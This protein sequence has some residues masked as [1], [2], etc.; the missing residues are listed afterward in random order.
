MSCARSTGSRSTSA[1]RRARGAARRER[2]RE[3]HAAVRAR[4]DPAPAARKRAAQ[5]HRGDPAQRAHA[6]RLPAA[7]GRHRLPGVQ[8]DPEPHGCR[9]RPGAAPRRRRRLARGAPPRRRSCWPRSAWPSGSRTAR[10]SC[11][12]GSS[13]AW[14][15]PRALALD[16][17]LLLADEPTAHLDYVQVD[18][19]L[20]LLREIADAGRMV[21]VATHDERLVPLADGVVELS[22]RHLEGV[23]ARGEVRLAPGEILFRQGDLSDLV[24]VV[25]HGR[26]RAGPGARGRRRGSPLALRERRVLRRAR[27]DVQVAALRHCA[28]DGTVP[29]FRP[30]GERLPAFAPA[31]ERHLRCARIAPAV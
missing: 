20:R 6:Q 17:P 1:T 25:D 31:T 16:P 14:P 3:D 8:P 5:R 15:S 23:P 26:C 24:Y 21:V 29:G 7:Q 4:G 9:E 18:G 22:P 11:R 28:G 10:A 13:S 12:A 27:P 19:V 30:P 2:L